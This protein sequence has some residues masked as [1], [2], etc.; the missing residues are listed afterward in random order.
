MRRRIGLGAFAACPSLRLSAYPT[1]L[2][3]GRALVVNALKALRVAQSC[4]T[5]VRG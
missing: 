4:E 5:D 2:E 3:N 1:T